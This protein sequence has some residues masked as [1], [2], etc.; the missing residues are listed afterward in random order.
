MELRQLAHFLAIAEER[1]FTRAAARVHLAQSSLSAS[2]G[3][4]EREVGSR[5]LLR[6]N[7]RVELT[8][9]GEALLPAARRALV[10]AADG[11][12]AIDAVRGLLRGRLSIGVIQFLSVL[13][14]PALL[15]HYHRLY[16]DIILS[17]RHDS[18]DALM[19]SM[20][21]GDLDLVIVDHP[22]DIRSV[23][24]CPLGTESL[25][26]A[27]A[28]D[29]P[30]ATRAKVSLTE[31]ADRA[32]VEFRADSTLRARIDIAFGMA[33]LTRQICCEIDNITE[34]VQLVSHGLGVAL[35]PSAP[36]LAAE[37]VT[38]I[39]VDPEIGRELILATPA[40]RPPAPA[41][42]MFIKVLETACD[43]PA[44]LD[45]PKHGSATS[46]G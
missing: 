11:Q 6:N 19:Q 23:H 38:A 21:D 45:V 4:L 17:V 10:A 43:I 26:L 5:L 41:A 12:A 46:G 2:I 18:V 31:I 40:D 35:L 14:V 3:T 22:L 7:R 28:D 1:H 13:D 20:L 24:T 25:M 36:I 33:G 37:R 8:E 34:L 32:F 16:P 39:D 44:S 30:L 29:D 9:T 42:A 27:V 15:T